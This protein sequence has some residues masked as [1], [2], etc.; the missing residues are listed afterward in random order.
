MSK[1]SRVMQ[2][3][4]TAISPGA[5]ETEFSMVRFKGD[6]EKADAVYRGIEPLTAEDIADHVHYA[7]T[8]C[9]SLW[10]SRTFQRY[11]HITWSSSCCLAS[12]GHANDVYMS[13]RSVFHHTSQCHFITV[14][15]PRATQCSQVCKLMRACMQASECP[16]SGHCHLCDS[17]EWAQGSSQSP[18]TLTARQNGKSVVANSW[19]PKIGPA[20]LK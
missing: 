13:H 11:C 3:R 18:T 14:Q 19:S 5:V 2:I 12:G 7:A 4:V 15:A 1:L 6:Q 8:R 16:D 17:S 9:A 20:G 10:V